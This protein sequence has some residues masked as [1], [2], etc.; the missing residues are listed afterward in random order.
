MTS[1]R[2]IFVVNNPKFFISHRIKI[3]EEAKSS[4]FEVHVA[5]G[6]GPELSIIEQSGFI[7]HEIA[8]KR[9]SMSPLQELKAFISLYRL[10]QQLKPDLVH[11]VT[12]KPVL[13]GTLAGRLAKVPA[14]VNAISGLGFVFTAAGTKAAAFRT[15]VQL[16]YRCI[17]RHSNMI[18]I[19]Q[20][21]DDQSVFLRARLVI[22]EQCRFIKGSG[23]DLNLFFPVPEEAGDPIILLPSRLLRD[24]GVVEF[25]EAARL[26]IRK[27]IKARFVLVGESDFG[28]PTA[29]DKEVIDEW[30]MEGCIEWWGYRTDMAKIMQQ[31]HIICLPSYREGLPKTLIE[32]TASGRSIVTTDVPGCRDVVTDGMNG[33][34]VPRQDSTALAAALEKLVIN[35]DLRQKMGRKGREKAEA[36]F[37]INNVV[38]KHL[39]IYNELLLG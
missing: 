24:K 5:T 10:Y 17:L 4:G 37:S 19:F 26:L 8:L 11:H 14:I 6:P 25:V 18:I 3:G 16:A 1:R 13:Y 36:E 15:L 9:G 32:A 31:A 20:N 38:Q 2:L 7:T 34:L 21:E 29:I 33:F 28:N 12:I 35:P 22:P 27:G 39:E 23:V 30:I